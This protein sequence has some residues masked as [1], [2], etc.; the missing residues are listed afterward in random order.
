MR[1]ID[2]KALRDLWGIKGQALAIA[3]VIASGVAIYIM[4]LSNSDSLRFSQAVYYE[5]NRFADVFANA[6]RAPRG[7]V[8]RIEEIPGVTA[9]ETRVV[10]GVTLDLEGMPEPV[11]GRLVSVPEGRPA[12]LNDLTLRRGRRPAPGRVEEVVV[13]EAFAEAQGLGPG[14]TFHA[15]L[16]GRRRELTVVGV[17]L[18][19]EY[20]YTVQ[21]GA[22]LPDDRRF[23]VLWMNR[24]ALEAAFDM[25]GGFND[26]SLRLLPTASGPEVI[27][28]LDRLLEPYGGTGAVP[29]ARQVSHW[30]VNDQLEQLEGMGRV[31]PLIF[32]GV[33][34]LLLTVVL[35]RI[36]TV[37]RGQIAALKALGYSNFAVGR[38][39]LLW[40]LAIAA[41]GAA[42][43]VLFGIWLG[44]A[45]LDLQA[46]FYRFPE[47]IFRLSPRVVLGSLA[48]SLGAAVVGALSAVRRAVALPPAEAMRP[49]PPGHFRRTLLERLG[50]G[51]LLTQPARMVVRGLERRPLRALASITGIAFGGAIFIVGIF[52]LDGMDRML[53]VQFGVAQRQ[54]VSVTFVEPV[55]GSALF[56]IGRL[57]GVIRAEPTR[58]VPVRLRFGH[59]SRQ[60]AISGMSRD[61]TLQRVIDASL[62]EVRPPADGLVLSDTLARVLGAGTGDTVIAEILEGPRPHREIEVA[63]V[64]EEYMGASA[65]MDLDA[66]HRL[67]HEGRSLSG[68]NLLVDAG[69]VDELYRRLKRLPAV[70]SV[71]LQSATLESFDR[72]VRDMLSVTIFFNVLFAAV[73]A[74]GVVYN[75]ARVSLSEREHELASLRVL[76][77][78]R[79]EISSILLGELAVL[80]LLA[81]PLGLAL[82]WALSALTV[83]AYETEVYRI[84]LVVSPR[85]LATSAITVIVSAVV[86]GLAVRRR[87]DRLDLVEVLKTRE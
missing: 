21:P 20:V 8:R 40:G 53:D 2:R 3:L 36:V 79:G 22:M 68:A 4:T 70:A 87:L 23:G 81:V 80:T 62:R 9:V 42:L 41:L 25:E 86:S 44:R 32:L 50:L 27:A 73:I 39:Y 54:D 19:P 7:L 76:G 15:I 13:H 69:H 14:D 85:V 45:M 5:D 65:Y 64:V 26:V 84:P 78:T 60:S 57:A 83:A 37:Q 43:G 63:D 17:A 47:L 28:R 10:A 61:A 66:L 34:A 52:S 48:V 82:G 33:G 74:F 35:N 38:H 56:E 24:R 58:S 67:M 46:Q 59:R 1:A 77:F 16:N 30:W 12:R 6:K 29:R 11:A 31:I 72:T 51:A 49:E 55:S 75:T 18:S 71:T